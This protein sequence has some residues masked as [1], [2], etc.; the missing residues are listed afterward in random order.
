MI[1]DSIQIKLISLIRFVGYS[2][3]S[4]QMRTYVNYVS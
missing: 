2:E 3:N 4:I 1:M